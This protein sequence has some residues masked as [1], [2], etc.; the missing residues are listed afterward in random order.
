V[1]RNRYYAGAPSDHFDGVR[2]FNPG[3]ASTD[4]SLG[5]RLRWWRGG[6]R[7]RWPARVTSAPPAK[8]AERVGELTITMIGHA[9]VLI[10]LAGCNLLVDPVW[11]ERASPVRWAGP[12][13][14]NDPGIVFADLP[15]IDAVLI[16]HNHYDHLDIATL[17]R[18]WSAHRPRFVVPLGNDV[19]LANAIGAG[20]AET[21]DWGDTIAIDDQ[22]RVTAVP[23]NH[24]SARTLGDRRMALWCG[25]VLQTPAGLIYDAGDTGYGD[26]GIF[27]DIARRFGAPDVA[28]LPIGAYEP[29]WFMKDQHVNPDEAVRIMM[30]CDARQALG[31]HW[32]TFQLTNEARLAPKEALAVALNQHG[33]APERFLALEP[34]DVWFKSG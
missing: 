11:S 34:G 1:G 27:S 16:T 9:S 32:G 6:D 25:F 4:R 33:I 22:I 3:Q 14:V 12:K 29:R 20:K 30:A 26:G 10:Q 5:A 28:I 7:S 15:P 21:V 31:V 13:R 19:L 18:L 23:A 8:P 2:I 24:W 17:R